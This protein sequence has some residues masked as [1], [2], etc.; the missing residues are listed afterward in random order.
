MCTL[1]LKIVKKYGPKKVPDQFSL[2]PFAENVLKKS[3]IQFT[4]KDIGLCNL[5]SG[6]RLYLNIAEYEIKKFKQNDDPYAKL[7]YEIC[8]NQGGILP[9]HWGLAYALHQFGK[10]LS[11]YK[12][13]IILGPD[14]QSSLFSTPVM[15][16][17][18]KYGDNFY[19]PFIGKNKFPITT[20]NFHTQLIDNNGLI[21]FFTIN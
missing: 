9:N 2:T 4:K 6:A 20:D 17:G 1:S 21:A 7:V 12:N 13:N 11:H 8:Q 18:D 5:P 10:Q 3:K 19:I 16:R 14:I 15:S